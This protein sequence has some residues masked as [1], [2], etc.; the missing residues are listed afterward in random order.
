MDQTQ[1]H[2]P[3]WMVA[4][5]PY[6]CV[7]MGLS[8]IMLVV[9][10]LINVISVGATTLGYVCMIIYAVICFGYARKEWLKQHRPT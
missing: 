6:F 9:L 1:P 10:D 4:L 7:F 2:L 5:S 8:S 3:K